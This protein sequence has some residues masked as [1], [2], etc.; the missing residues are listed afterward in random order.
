MTV[1]SHMHNAHSLR[2]DFELKHF[3]ANVCCIAAEIIRDAIHVCV[4]WLTRVHLWNLADHRGGGWSV[5]LGFAAVSAAA[6][7][8]SAQPV[9]P[10]RD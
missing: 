3:C 5:A 7:R 8:G 2:N 6:D 1:A 4:A 9:N 10:D